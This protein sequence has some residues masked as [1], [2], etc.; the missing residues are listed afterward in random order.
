MTIIHTEVTPDYKTLVKKSRDWL[1]STLVRVL[2]DIQTIQNKHQKQ[3]KALEEERDLAINSNKCAETE[4]NRL[5]TENASLRLRIS[6][7][8]ILDYDER[9]ARRS[10]LWDWFDQE[11]DESLMD[12]DIDMIEEI[13]I[14]KVSR[15]E[16]HKQVIRSFMQFSDM[17][18][19]YPHDIEE[20]LQLF[21]ESE[22]FDKYGRQ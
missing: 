3:V 16:Y 7:W 9:Q 2:N 17:E 10:A 14:K 12:S 13:M 11:Y 15:H 8:N 6:D 4:A 19:Y 5:N 21:V 20:K 1:A 22:Q 18:N